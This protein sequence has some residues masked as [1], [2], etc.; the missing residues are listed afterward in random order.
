MKAIAAAILALILLMGLAAPLLTAIDPAQINPVYRNK[1]PGTEEVVRRDDGTKTT[2]THWMGTD[3]LGR[4]IY[5]RVLY[6]T[7]VSLIVG[8]SSEGTAGS[9]CRN[10][11]VGGP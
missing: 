11:R 8:A 9:A 5:S 1:K 10:A 6:G 4:D 2:I 3:S 7:R